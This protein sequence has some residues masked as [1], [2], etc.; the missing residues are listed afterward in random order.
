[1]KWSM[2]DAIIVRVIRVAGL[3]GVLW[4]T[5]GEH[6]D[7]PYLLFPLRFDDGARKMGQYRIDNEPREWTRVPLE[8]Q[9]ARATSILRR[10][11][12]NLHR[13]SGRS[14]LVL[15]GIGL[16][17]LVFLYVYGDTGRAALCACRRH[18]RRRRAR[19]NL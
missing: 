5:F 16:V 17:G 15:L 6:V 9:S 12:V 3:G 18:A 11:S 14:G 13:I 1:M 19:Y 4:E 7:R 8:T 2:L 10:R